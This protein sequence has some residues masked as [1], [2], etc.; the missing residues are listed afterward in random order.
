[1]AKP[2]D[3][4]LSLQANNLQKSFQKVFAEILYVVKTQPDEKSSRFRIATIFCNNMHAS[5]EHDNP[6]TDTRS[7]IIYCVQ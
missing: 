5:L 6:N 3:R 1:M 7:Q 2:C 4:L